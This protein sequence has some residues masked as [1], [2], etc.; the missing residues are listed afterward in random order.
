ME[1]YSV[2]FMIFG[3]LLL[4]CVII[5]FVWSYQKD[6]AELARLELLEKEHEIETNIDSM[7]LSDVVKL[8]NSSRDD[9]S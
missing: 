6:K 4:L 5:W 7:A 3:L 8:N 1:A 2:D 9:K